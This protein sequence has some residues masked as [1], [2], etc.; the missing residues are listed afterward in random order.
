MSDLKQTILNAIK[1]A[2]EQ[3]YTLVRES[4]GNAEAKCACPLSCVVLADNPHNSTLI[5]DG[6]IATKASQLLN[7]SYDWALAFMDGYDG[8]SCVFNSL[9]DKEAWKQAWKLGE[10]ICAE[11]SPVLYGDYM[12][13][14][15]SD[16]VKWK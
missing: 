12:R 11:T 1:Q 8:E 16:N 10:Q 13:E 9:H 7:V 15:G 4:Y 14:K 5:D 3:G 6:L 2:Q